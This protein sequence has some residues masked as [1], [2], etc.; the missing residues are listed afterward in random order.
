MNAKVKLPAY[1]ARTRDPQGQGHEMQAATA[2]TL[3]T[4]PR[5]R[6]RESALSTFAPGI[7]LL[8]MILGSLI[9]LTFLRKPCYPLNGKAQFTL[10]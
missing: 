10:L 4:F 1:P 2:E 6:E 8:G 7:S 5:M 3:L 9:R